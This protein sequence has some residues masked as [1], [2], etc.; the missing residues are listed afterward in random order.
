MKRNLLNIVG[1]TA[2]IATVFIASLSGAAVDLAENAA[3]LAD[4]GTISTLA[5]SAVAQAAVLGDVTILAET[6]T[7]AATI[8]AALKSAQDA[9]VAC[10]LALENGDEEGAADAVKDLDA[11]LAEA[12]GALLSAVANV[13]PKK[14]SVAGESGGPGEAGDP[15][16]I[17]EE[18]W[19][20]DSMRS[21]YQSLFGMAWSASAQG[22]TSFAE[23][24]ATE[25]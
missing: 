18:L 10:E 2:F 5:Q 15:P 3:K 4:I 19:Q 11:A 12:K 13:A 16:N 17:Y 24:D 6:T 7:R 20:T 1:C 25:I 14:E 22:G 23:R 21:F 8:D 9:Y